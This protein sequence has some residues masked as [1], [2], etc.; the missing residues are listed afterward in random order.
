MPAAFPQK[1]MF[2]PDYATVIRSAPRLAIGIPSLVISAPSFVIGAPRCVVRTSILVTGTRRCSQTCCQC[3]QAS[4]CCTQVL[5]GLSPD[6]LYALRFFSGA[7]WCTWRP[8]HR[9]SKLWNLTTLG[10]SSK[11]PTQFQRLPEI[12]MHFAD[13]AKNEFK[14]YC[15]SQANCWTA[16]HKAT[17]IWLN[18]ISI[19]FSSERIWTNSHGKVFAW[20]EITI[21]SMSR[22]CL[23]VSVALDS[24]VHNCIDEYRPESIEWGCRI[25]TMAICQINHQHGPN[26]SVWPN[27]AICV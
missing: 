19:I 22:M 2:F 9:F 11:T 1:M 26:G 6:L 8:L 21:L 16:N 24:N 14:R 20:W 3:T 13:V 4:G 25:S 7:A 12:K 17:S 18:I 23:I 10:F 15:L 27:V 5:P